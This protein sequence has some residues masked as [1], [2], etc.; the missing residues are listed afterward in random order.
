MD[1][2]NT[3]QNLWCIA[4]AVLGGNLWPLHA[5]IRKEEG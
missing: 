3:F 4:N 5:Y 2:K 1:N